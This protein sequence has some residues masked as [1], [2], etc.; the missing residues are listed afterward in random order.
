MSM[1]DFKS[2]RL[3]GFSKFLHSVVM[4]VTYPFRHPLKL[5]ILLAVV[6]GIL[7]VVPIV[8]GVPLSAAP[9]WYM[10]QARKI[11]NPMPSKNVVVK[12]KTAAKKAEKP[13]KFAK[14]IQLKHSTV[15]Q[16]V[17]EP[18]AQKADEKEK[19]AVWNIAP[20][21]VEPKAVEAENNPLIDAEQ[22]PVVQIQKQP[23]V[24]FRKVESLPLTYLDEPEIIFG[25][26]IIY[27]PNEFYIEGKYLYLYGIFTDPAKYDVAK[28]Q[29]YLRELINGEKVE[30]YIIAK[31]LDGI[32][33]A[34]C[35]KDGRSINQSLVDAGFAD[36][37]AL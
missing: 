5:L 37:I 9:A 31:T 23:K 21:E 32:E 28:A 3:H 16:K 30:C 17:A 33:T 19:Y 22:A 13:K 1:G 29:T 14:P 35:L 27:G 2:L 20:K 34:I 12:V 8:K 18:V 7:C 25:S 6:L 26:V 24:Q 15:K 4:F 36:N 10:A 11:L